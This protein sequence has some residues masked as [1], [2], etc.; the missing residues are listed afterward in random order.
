MGLLSESWMWSLHRKNKGRSLPFIVSNLSQGLWKG[1]LWICGLHFRSTAIFQNDNS[2][3]RSHSHML[4]LSVYSFLCHFLI[5]LTYFLNFVLHITHLV[6]VKCLGQ[7]THILLFTPMTFY[8]HLNCDLSEWNTERW[9][10]L[11][12]D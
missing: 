2:L 5:R 8:V 3:T 4:R 12:I 9:I 11:S 1:R 6:H 7:V 10:H